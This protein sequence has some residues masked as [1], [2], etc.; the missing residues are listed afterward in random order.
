[1]AVYRVRPAEKFVA[2]PVQV[3]W[4]GN[5]VLVEMEV[6]MRIARFPQLQK[7]AGIE[8]F[9]SFPTKKLLPCMIVAGPPHGAAAAPEAQ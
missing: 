1:M 2:C 8:L 7:N 3:V 5:Y 6:L 4:Q 9:W